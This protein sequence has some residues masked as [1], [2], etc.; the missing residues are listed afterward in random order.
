[1]LL[2]DGITLLYL[3][4]QQPLLTVSSLATAKMVTA[5]AVLVHSFVA[6]WFL[7]W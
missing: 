3:K 4:Q 6:L 2:E 7:A 1:V 5:A